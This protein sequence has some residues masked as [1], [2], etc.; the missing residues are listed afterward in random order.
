MTN[1]ARDLKKRLLHL[2]PIK[3]IKDHYN[4]TGSFEDIVETLSNK[5]SADLYK[6]AHAHS[7]LTRQNIYL[8]TLDSNF[9]PK[10]IGNNFPY[11]IEITQTVNGEHHYCCF[12]KTT[13]SVYLSFPVTSKVELSFLQPVIIKCSGKNLIIHFTKL[14]KSLGSYFPNDPEAKKASVQMDQHEI[15]I[16]ILDYFGQDYTVSS[17]DFNKGIKHLW[18][19]DDIDCFKIQSSNPHSVRVETMNGELTFK[20]KYPA[21]YKDIILKPLGPSQWKYL[22]NDDYLCEGFTAD[23]NSGN[24]SIT[25]FPKTVNQVINVID[26]ILT[27]N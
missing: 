4:L 25:R 13:F 18:D 19:I 27:N 2:F 7:I 3:S 20:E 17:N 12:P 24:I 21:E 1:N 10:T 26:K 5:P 15:L 8:Y 23:P 6:F 9:S 14:E 22:R 16:N 11:N